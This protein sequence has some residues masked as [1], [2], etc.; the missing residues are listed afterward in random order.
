MKPYTL[1]VSACVIVAGFFHSHLVAS[2]AAIDL[3]K[4]ELETVARLQVFDGQNGDTDC[5]AYRGLALMLET[6]P[7]GTRKYIYKNSDGSDGG[8][9]WAAQVTFALRRVPG[10]VKG[11]SA[12]PGILG[13]K[14]SQVRVTYIHDRDYFSREHTYGYFPDPAA[15]LE[16]ADED[17]IV[18]KR[19][20]SYHMRSGAGHRHAHKDWMSSSFFEWTLERAFTLNDLI[21]SIN[22]LRRLPSSCETGRA[23]E[24][25]L[26]CLRG[27]HTYRTSV[28]NCA[29]F[30]VQLLQMLGAID[31]D[32]DVFSDYAPP[33]GWPRFGTVAAVLGMGTLAVATGG[34]FIL[35]A[36][37]LEAAGASTALLVGTGVA[38]EVAV[39]ATGYTVG[40]FVRSLRD[41]VSPESAVKS[42]TNHYL[43][44]R[45]AS[46]YLHEA[47]GITLA[48]RPR[49]VRIGGHIT[50]LSGLSETLADD[51]RR[52]INR[53][54]RRVTYN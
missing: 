31:R 6:R 11:N 4:N 18:L 24:F 52:T 34:G 26:Y 37:F 19:W 9:L 27:A 10:L 13:A 54:D 35:G 1:Y 41:I 21:A 38:A 12:T 29:T 43:R 33:S 40:G 25:P 44:K 2:T 36:M 45:N 5:G 28:L 7:C 23:E 8:Y 46:T 39:T 50:G 15:I 49:V 22:T 16:S 3:G 53:S 47:D 20:A 51:V 30:S 42:L 14:K 32:H 48:H 17:K